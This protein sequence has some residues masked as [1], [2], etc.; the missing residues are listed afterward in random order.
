MHDPL[1]CAVDARN[2]WNGEHYE[3][4]D[5]VSRTL[6]RWLIVQIYTPHNGISRQT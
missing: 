3:L 2:V 5:V 6:D 4:H 1:Q